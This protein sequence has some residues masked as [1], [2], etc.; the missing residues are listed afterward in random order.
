MRAVAAKKIPKK[1]ISTAASRREEAAKR[2]E[3]VRRQLDKAQVGTFDDLVRGCDPEVQEIARR[4]Q[5]LVFEVIPDAEEVTYLRWRITLYK[6]RTEICGIQPAGDRCNFYLTKGAYLHD[7]EGILEGTG[8]LIRHVKVRSV[9]G[10]AAESIREL[11][12]QA[13]ELSQR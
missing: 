4:L 3:A 8:K 11:L 9:V 12:K 7:P 5:A 10:T 6:K 2:A 1:K 13:V